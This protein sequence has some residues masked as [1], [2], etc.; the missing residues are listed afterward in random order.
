EVVRLLLGLVPRH[1]YRSRQPEEDK[2]AEIAVVAER[3]RLKRSLVTPP[4]DE[5]EDRA[6]ALQERK[7]RLEALLVE[8]RK[9]IDAVRGSSAPVD[10]AIAEEQSALEA[11]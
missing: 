2:R 9:G 6:H 7:L 1:P 4:T 5:D 3:V 8:S 11:L 10:Q